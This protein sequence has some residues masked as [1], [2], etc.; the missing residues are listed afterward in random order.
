MNKITII[1]GSVVLALILGLLLV[2]PKY[3][4]Y[5]ILKGN[6]EEK[7]IEL[8]SKEQYY[9]EIKT[10]S[11]KMGTYEESLAKVSSALPKDA[12]VSSLVNFFQMTASESGLL[13]KKIA[14]GGFVDVK[15]SSLKEFQASFQLTGSYE[16]L[17]SF[18]AVVENSSRM[19]EITNVSLTAG[20]E[21]LETPASYT[22]EIKAYSY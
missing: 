9:A 10:A 12:S 3:Q 5:Q 7:Q 2:W 16:A 21:E 4:D 6:I 19:I 14:L 20:D 18:V 13:M 15:N 8:D 1:A 22:L 17:K 11:T